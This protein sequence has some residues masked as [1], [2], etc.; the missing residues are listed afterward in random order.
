[1]FNILIRFLIE[2]WSHLSQLPFQLLSII[3]L[4]RSP[5]KIGINSFRNETYENWII[6][7]SAIHRFKA[8][9]PVSSSAQRLI[10]RA[11][12]HLSEAKR[13]YQLVHLI[14]D[15]VFRSLA[16]AFVPLTPRETA[17]HL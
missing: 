1:M 16:A 11:I 7:Q 5:M 8:V 17:L 14:K 3:L 12:M 15:T 4:T 6:F 10:M 13:L 2:I 9:L